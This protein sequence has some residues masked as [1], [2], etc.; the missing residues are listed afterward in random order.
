MKPDLTPLVRLPARDAQGHKG[1][2]GTVVVVGGCAEWNRPR[3]IGAPALVARAA[4]RSG[5]GL[6]RVLVPEPI[7]DDVVVLMPSAVGVGLAVDDEHTIIP[8]EAAEVFD[9]E[10][11]SARAVVIGPG[12][13]NS[14]ATHPIVLRAVQQDAIPVVVDADALNTLAQTPEF[15]RDLRATAILTPHPG[16]FRRLAE[17]LKITHDPTV[18]AQRP[19][20]AEAMAQRLGCVVV[21]KGAGTIVTDGHR[22]WR[23]AVDCPALATGGTGDVLAGL[24]GG[25]VAQFVQSPHAVLAAH[26]SGTPVFDAYEAAR[27]GVQAHANA[28]ERWVA[29]HHASGGLLAS[30]LADL[31]PECLERLRGA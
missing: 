11:G 7:V 10:T 13:G 6:C 27:L 23:C 24:I 3:M 12:L 28:G 17:P 5:A 25:L 18:E 4:L 16:E 2:F 15:W 20:A 30:E 26:R 22:T 8:H 1:T 19:L 31:L 14:P 9:R 21:L 29:A